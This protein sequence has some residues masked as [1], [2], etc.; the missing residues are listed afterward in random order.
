MP[1]A[2][3]VGSRYGG[4]GR[5]RAVQAR[6][7]SC[8]KKKEAGSDARGKR[9]PLRA[10]L[11]RAPR[12]LACRPRRA[13]KGRL[14]A[15]RRPACRRGRP[16]PRGGRRS[17]RSGRR[18]R[19]RPGRPRRRSRARR[20]RRRG[21]S[22]PTATRRPA[23][24]AASR[25]AASQ[26][27]SA[28]GAASPGGPRTPYASTVQSRPRGSRDAGVEDLDHA[29]TV[30]SPAAG[31]AS[32]AG[33]AVPSACVEIGRPSG[34]HSSLSHFSAMTRLSWLGR[35]ARNRH[36]HA[37]ERRR[38]DGVEAGGRAGADFHTAQRARLQQAPHR[39]GHA[40][41]RAAAVPHAR[42]GTSR[43][44]SPQTA[45]GSPPRT[46]RRALRR[47]GDGDGAVAPRA[48]QHARRARDARRA[49]RLALGRRR[50]WRP[51]AAPR[52]AAGAPRPRRGPRPAA[53]P[54]ARRGPPGRRRTRA[55]GRLPK[56][57]SSEPK[58]RSGAFASRDATT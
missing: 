36:R 38:V 3:P 41:R 49:V 13:N 40:D 5:G 58:C 31:M 9:A 11:V 23:T 16:P 35:A 8:G 1:I 25:A 10:R 4:G 15:P 44:R 26:A 19:P 12:R 29:S 30:Q 34:D 55:S 42:G 45:P 24:F 43:R 18:A 28:S 21:R 20:P 2:R 46:P 50:R 53:A 33:N 57:R 27:V 14:R 7:G 52:A 39:D 54:C 48:V 37:I 22:P 56:S 32:A 17:G 6:S 47:P 51:T